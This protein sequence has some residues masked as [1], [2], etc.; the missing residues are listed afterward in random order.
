[1]KKFIVRVPLAIL[2]IVIFTLI[3]LLLLQSTSV[4]LTPKWITNSDSYQTNTMKGYY[5]LPDNTLDALYLGSSDVY[6]GVS[7]MEIWN[8]Y[9]IT[10]Y[11][12]AFTGARM[13]T[14][15]YTLREALRSQSP[16]VVFMEMESTFSNGLSKEVNTRKT[17]DYMEW[18][19]VKW[20]ALNDPILNNSSFDILSF[21]FPVLRY[22]DRISQLT[23]DDFTAPFMNYHNSQK[24]FAITGKVNVPDE[25]KI[26]SYMK[27]TDD[28]PQIE[29]RV[30][31]YFEQIV[32]LCKE[33]NI[34]LVLFCVPSIENWSYARHN[35][36]AALAKDYGVDFIDMNMY[37]SDIGIDWHK[38]TCD[39]GTHLNIT[40]AQKVSKYFGNI[41]SKDYSLP[42]HRND[43]SYYTW[44]NDYQ[45]YLL[46]ID[47]TNVDEAKK[48]QLDKE[49]QEAKE[50]AAKAATITT[51]NQG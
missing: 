42:D 40:G 50:R 31:K 23:P 9:G 21:I 30:L 22:H 44:N 7:P 46:N 3:M 48:V 15:Y 34:Q 39:K 49:A 51:A 10:G 17:Y 38:D 25:D 11:D 16:K 43:D 20:D 13:W 37:A 33:N 45:D 41:I 27:K 28:A 2:K 26:T 8:Q 5:D 47:Q 1:M 18:S 4:L 35:S 36:T 12:F 32:N 19:Q 6:R 29:N 24:G 14:N